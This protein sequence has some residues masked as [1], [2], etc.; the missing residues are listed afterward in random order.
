MAL[1]CRAHHRRRH[2]GLRWGGCLVDYVLSVPSS[3][4]F[5]A[6]PGAVSLSLSPIAHASR[7]D[8]GRISFLG[9]VSHVT[10]SPDRPIAM[11]VAM[12]DAIWREMTSSWA[13]DPGLFSIRPQNP[14]K[15]RF[16]IRVPYLNKIS[17][18]V[19]LSREPWSRVQT[20][21]R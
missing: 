8:Q 11:L 16:P 3:I 6:G 2:E 7:C 13:A 15:R 5:V 21:R 10:Q 20:S 17:I 12:L 14:V 19:R 1:T 18:R 4:Q 9:A